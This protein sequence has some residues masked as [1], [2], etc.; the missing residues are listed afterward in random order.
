[1]KGNLLWFAGAVLV[2]AGLPLAFVLWARG[3]AG[4]ALCLLSFY[5]INP[6]FF[7]ALG[8][9]AGRQPKRRWILLIAGAG[10]YL[11]AMGGLF[12]WREP[13]FALY[14]A[15]YLLLGSVAALLSWRYGR[16]KRSR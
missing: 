5:G 11:F 1:M 15:G 7:L 6:L 12:T 10:I 14:A 13:A 9:F 16:G 3:D 2:L 4:M 8:I